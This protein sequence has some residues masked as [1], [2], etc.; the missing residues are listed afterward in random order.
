MSHRLYLAVCYAVVV[1]MDLPGT[2]LF[3]TI[4]QR[5]SGPIMHIV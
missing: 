1:L 4:A 2:L 3:R 5:I